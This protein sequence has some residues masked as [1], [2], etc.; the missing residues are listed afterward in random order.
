MEDIPIYNAYDICQYQ[1]CRCRSCGH[2]Q[3]GNCL[4]DTGDCTEAMGLG[5]C[6]I[7]SCPMYKSKGGV[8]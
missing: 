3:R 7:G 6:P 2:D 5:R 4:A 8:A 1:S